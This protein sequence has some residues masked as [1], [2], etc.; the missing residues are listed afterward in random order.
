M[1][2]QGLFY[3]CFSAKSPLPERGAGS[4]TGPGF[5]GPGLCA[6]EAACGILPIPFCAP[7]IYQTEDKTVYILATLIKHTPAEYRK[8]A[9]FIRDTKLPE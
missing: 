2:L 9:G 7:R 6:A 1:S 3:A 4:S 8:Y 5:A